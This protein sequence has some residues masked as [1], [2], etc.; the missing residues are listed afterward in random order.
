MLGSVGSE[1][2]AEFVDA[3]GRKREADGVSVAAEAGEDFVTALDGFEQMK[4]GNG[5]AGT[6]GFAVFPRDDDGR[7]AGLVDDARGENADDAAVPVVAVHDD[8]ARFA[9][10]G[11]VE[12]G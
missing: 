3:I 2:R 5:A 4:A 7:L 8:A 6:V 9:E 11:F 10:A 1:P 12:A